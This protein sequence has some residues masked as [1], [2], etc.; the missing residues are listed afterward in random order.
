[1]I[2]KVL[3]ILFSMAYLGV[4]VYQQVRQRKRGGDATRDRADRGSLIVLYVGIA[5]G[6][7]MAFALS[8]SKAG[9]LPGDQPLWLLVGAVLIVAGLLVRRGAMRTLSELF[10]FEVEIAGDHRL[11]ESGIYRRIRH[12]G[13]LGQILVFL[14][15]AVALANALGVVAMLVATLVAFGWRIRVEEAAL[16]A[17][18]GDAYE[19]YRRRTSRLVP[20]IY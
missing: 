16:A 12:P 18:F 17:R 5:I 7:S 15:A 9:R 8:F 13:Y 2:D 11:V 6:Y 1:M 4:E 19:A 14:G 3:V 20:G 10:T